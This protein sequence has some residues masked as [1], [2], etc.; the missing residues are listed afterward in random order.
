MGCPGHRRRW[1]A[2]RDQFATIAAQCRAP[3]TQRAYARAQRDFTA[4]HASVGGTAAAFPVH[5][6]TAQAWL[7]LATQARP[8]FSVIKSRFAALQAAQI[9]AG[10]PPLGEVP[11]M[12]DFLK[13]AARALAAPLRQAPPMRASFLAKLRALTLSTPHQ[14]HDVALLHVLYAACL[15]GPSE[16]L[17]LCVG[18]VRF[19]ASQ[20]AY[21]VRVGA[22]RRTKTT[23]SPYEAFERWV[24]EPAAGVLRRWLAVHPGV[25]Q[26]DWP[27]FCSF[28]AAGQPLWATPATPSSLAVICREWAGRVG[29]PWASNATSHGLRRGRIT[30]LMAAGHAVDHVRKLSGHRSDAILAYVSPSAAELCALGRF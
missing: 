27:L 21:V 30:D 24:P 6:P 3:S 26:P 19:D 29:E 25:R 20:E 16:L 4:F 12:R 14:L 11:V 28:N 10:G 15:R 7:G 23:A 8:S 5:L 1:G 9:A 13:G 18:D 22:R 2:G 17:P